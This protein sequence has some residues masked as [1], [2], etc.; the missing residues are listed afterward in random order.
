MTDDQTKLPHE[1]EDEPPPIGTW[2]R[3]YI[4]TLIYLAFVIF[5]FYLFEVYFAP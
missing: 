5:S 1:I 3:V 4:F 2:R